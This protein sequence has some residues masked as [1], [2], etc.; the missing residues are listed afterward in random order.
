MYYSLFVASFISSCLNMVRLSS[1]IHSRAPLQ[2][3][4]L[5]I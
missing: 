5:P 3:N 4:S 1:S 2:T